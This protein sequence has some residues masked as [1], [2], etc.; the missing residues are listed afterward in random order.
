MPIVLF[1]DFGAADPYVGQVK[2]ALAA[3]APRTPVY[4]ALHDA[5]AF[6]IEPSAHLLAALA[7]RYPLGS[8]FMAVV[9]PGVGGS[10]GALVIDVDGRSFVAPD[11][12]LLSVLWQRARERRCRGICWRPPNMSNSFH[13][14]DLFA[15]VA[16]AL[17]VRRVPRGWL[18]LLPGPEVVLPGRDLGRVIYVDHYGNAM[19]GLRAGRA[20]RGTCVRVGRRLLR[21]AS[22]FGDVPSRTPFWYVNSLGLVELAANRANA[23][24]LLRLRVGSCVAMERV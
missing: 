5:P 2:A 17:A 22:T 9:D 13:G 20:A 12:G 1:T 14:R 23:A 10:R 15:P 8:I 4:D 19:T 21:Y 6:S 11:N 7:P 18:A 24:R 16:A 3:R